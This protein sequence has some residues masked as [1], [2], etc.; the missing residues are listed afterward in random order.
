MSR[1][2]IVSPHFENSVFVGVRVILSDDD[3]IISSKDYHEGKEMTWQDAMDALKE[4]NLS[5]WDYHQ[6]CLTMA[7]RNEIDKLLEDNG[8]DKL[9]SRYWIRTNHSTFYAFHYCTDCDSLFDTVKI[10]THKVRTI[11]NLKTEL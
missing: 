7:Y 11:K 1:N 4:D 5:T 2:N 6:V 9:N 3:F 8:G 10:S